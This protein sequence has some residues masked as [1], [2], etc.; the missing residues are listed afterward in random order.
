MLYRQ[1]ATL[2]AVVLEFDGCSTSRHPYMSALP[3]AHRFPSWQ[4]HIVL[5]AHTKPPFEPLREVLLKYLKMNVLFLTAV[6]LARNVSESG[7]LPEKVCF[8]YKVIWS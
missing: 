3:I 6:T 5:L 7:A 4:L 8:L 2:A 1:V